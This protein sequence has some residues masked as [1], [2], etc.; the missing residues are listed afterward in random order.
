MYKFLSLCQLDQVG[1]AAWLSS[2]GPDGYPEMKKLQEVEN[3]GKAVNLNKKFEFT[4]PATSNGKG[5][6][7][8]PLAGFIAVDFTNVL[9]GPN[10]G[11]M[12]SELGATVYKVEPHNPQ[13]P[14]MVMVAW[15][16]EGNAG[17]KTIILD[18]HT[19]KGKEVMYDLVKL[20]DVCI[21]NKSD[22]QVVNMGLDRETLSKFN[23][24]IIHL[25]LQ[26]RKGEDKT[27]DS[28]NWPGYDPA[29]QGKTGISKR[30]GPPGCPTLHGVA[31]C[32]DYC[33]AY[34]GAWSGLTAL[35]TR[36]AN[37]ITGESAGASLALTAS[38]MQFTHLGD[39]DDSNIP[40]GPKATGPTQFT[41]VYELK[42][43]P[44]KWVYVV[45]DCDL[46]KEMEA[47]YKSVDEAIQKLADRGYVAVEVHSTRL[48]A[49]RNLEG[50]SKTV[51]Y[52]NRERNG[53][54]TR[55]W[56]P[57]WICYDNE[58]LEHPGAVGPTGCDKEDILENVLGY[59]TDKTRDLIQGGIVKQDYWVD[60]K[61]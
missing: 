41:R 16:A 9:A 25:N 43:I 45:A 35:Y 42:T 50:D 34:L 53:L 6:S 61:N 54:H 17:K 52:E 27:A 7:K 28:A 36:E 13:H 2:V 38:I 40:V 29:L 21:F 20:A 32:V 44:G 11:R 33:T 12:L 58:P 60:C 30:F 5:I 3:I 57:T 46:S 23:P 39:G 24:K 14:P 15:Q 18:M 51:C 55:T 47:D 10:C 49:D 22:N 8:K 31:S 26:A 37:G 1:R 59:N 4:N 56:K 19:D 48:I